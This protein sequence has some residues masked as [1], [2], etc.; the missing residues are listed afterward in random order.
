MKKRRYVEI[1]ICGD[2]EKGSKLI[3]GI[4]EYKDTDEFCERGG[5]TESKKNAD[6]E[7]VQRRCEERTIG[8]Y[9]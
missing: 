5:K 9:F 4:C 1:I 8:K 7:Q 3:K 6:E 2:N